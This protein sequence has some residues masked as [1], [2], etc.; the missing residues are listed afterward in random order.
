MNGAPSFITGNM[1]KDLQ[2]FDY[3][4][5][6]SARFSMGFTPRIKQ[7][8]Q[9]GNGPIVW[10]RVTVWDTYLAQHVLNSLHK[11]DPV[12]V[13]GEVTTEEYQG[14]TN[15][16]LNAQF[17]GVDLSWRDVTVQPRQQSNA[18]SQNDAWGN[19]GG[20]GTPMDEPPF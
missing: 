20:F 15:F 11:G 4:G 19:T 9:W 6:T 1:G 14:Q 5:K 7:N 18:A 17:V 3:Q 16:N 13:Y 8:G 2:K 12:G 10:Y